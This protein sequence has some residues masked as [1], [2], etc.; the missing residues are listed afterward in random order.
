MEFQTA[1]NAWSH[2]VWLQGLQNDCP[3]IDGIVFT[4]C[5]FVVSQSSYLHHTSVVLLN[6]NSIFSHKNSFW[7]ADV[8]FEHF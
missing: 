6:L 7:G 1:E 8:N 4:F 5:F 3:L 2:E